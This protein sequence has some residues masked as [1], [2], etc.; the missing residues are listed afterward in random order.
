M[1]SKWPLLSLGVLATAV[2]MIGILVPLLPTTPF[3]LLAAACFVRS[4]DRMYGWLTSN[5]LFGGFIRDY[6]EQRGVS[7]RAKIMALALLW[8]VIGYT[9]LTAVTAIWLRVLLA[10][11]A[12]GVTVHL[13][14]LRTSPKGS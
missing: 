1:L 11:V 8:G 5:R 14:R 10:A 4:S 13:L 2:G 9:A 7:A 12:L 3:L 6:R